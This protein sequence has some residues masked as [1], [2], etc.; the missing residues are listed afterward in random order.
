MAIAQGGW[1]TFAV[2]EFTR[3]ESI[4]KEIGRLYNVS[5]TDIRTV[6]MTG[7]T[8]RAGKKMVAAKRSDWKKAMVR[9]AKGQKIAVFDI[10]DAAQK[11]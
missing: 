11:A 9:L 3:K 5:V 1:Y 8:R 10:G 7:K 4:A 2:P 6:S